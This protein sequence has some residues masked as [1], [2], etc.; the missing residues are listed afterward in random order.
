MLVELR[1]W[2]GGT[3]RRDTLP[4]IRLYTFN[5]FHTDIGEKILQVTQDGDKDTLKMDA[6]L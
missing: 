4:N 2:K 6:G 1:P 5:L 3:E